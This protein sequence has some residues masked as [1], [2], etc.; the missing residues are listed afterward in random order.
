MKTFFILFFSLAFACP[1][2][3]FTG[4]NLPKIILPKGIEKP[5]RL[6]VIKSGVMRSIVL[7]CDFSDNRHT[8][9]L[10]EFSNL[11]FGENPP[12]LRSYYYEV[13]Y[14]NLTIE[15]RV[16][17]WQR[18]DKPYSYYVGDSFGVYKEFPNNSQGLVYD[19]IEKVDGMVNFREY[20]N[21]NDGYVDGLIVIHSGPGAEETG[22]KRDFWS[23]KWNLS[24]NSTGCPGSYRTDDGVSIDAYTLQPERF[25]NGSLITIGVFAHEFG[26]ILGLPDLY[27]TD[28]SSSGLGIFCLMAAGCWAKRDASSLPGSSP[29]HPNSW[30]KYLLG[31]LNPD[32]LQKGFS[33]EKFNASLFA[34]SDTASAYRLI[35][36]P[37]G[38]DWTFEA[39]GMGEY[40]LVENRYQ[41]GFDVGLPGS[42]LLIL[43]IDETRQGNDDERHPLV[44]ILRPGKTGF[45][46]PKYSWGDGGDLWKNDTVG[47]CEW[48]TPNSDFYS[49]L[50]SGVCV[51]NISS[52]GAV[53]T[54]DLAIEPVLLGKFYAYPNPFI[55][56]ENNLLRIYYCP[57][58]TE[59]IREKP[60]FR[61]H[62][63]TL[64]GEH[65]ATVE[66]DA[67]KRTAFW[68]LKN[69]RGKD[70]ASGLYF[71][72]IEIENKG[73]KERQR[74]F[75]SVVR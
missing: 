73:R 30:C 1:P 22:N 64:S 41:K 12:S 24:D 61:V 6:K 10:S 9:P 20:D 38:P 46:I 16:I 40:F 54:A 75:F 60:P 47:L 44:G 32:S 56:K 65:V 2:N 68:D 17:E 36:N 42:G 21:D 53:M 69:Q 19:L 4:K 27:D 7:L 66:G 70:V 35:E 33:V 67:L 23:H 55:K 13:S 63:Y 31:W 25:E 72:I 18:M 58:D 71:Y 62:I 59:R 3:P 34:L 26:H 49:G 50:P 14:G 28:Y 39:P 51:K 52:P 5:E 29:V 37:L 11:L 48:T 45:A 8:Y 57:S 15:G 74:G 43:H